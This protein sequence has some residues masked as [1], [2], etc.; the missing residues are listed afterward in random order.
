MDQDFGTLTCVGQNEV[1]EQTNPC[2]FQ[3]ILAG[4]NYCPNNK[5]FR[6]ERQ[7]KPNS[8]CQKLFALEAIINFAGTLVLKGMLDLWSNNFP[9]PQNAVSFLNFHVA[10][11]NGIT[12]AG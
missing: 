5:R 11:N 1:G 12:F 10:E 8:P 4:K 9:T 3:V 6:D 2:V 7:V